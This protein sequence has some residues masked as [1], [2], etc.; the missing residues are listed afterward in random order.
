MCAAV[1]GSAGAPATSR[2]ARCE[3][4]G[5]ALA[6]AGRPPAHV[7]TATGGRGAKQAAKP[8]A[9]PAQGRGGAAAAP[10]RPRRR[11]RRGRHRGRAGTHARAPPGRAAAVAPGGA[12]PAAARRPARAQQR[13][14][15]AR[16]DGA[17]ASAQRAPL[18]A[19]AAGASP[20]ATRP[21][22]PSAREAAA[23]A[24][25]GARPDRSAAGAWRAVAGGASAR[26]R[27]AARAS[28]RVAAVEAVAADDHARRCAS[29]MRRS[30]RQERCSMYQR[31]SSMRSSHGSAARPLTCAQP[32]MPGL[33]RQAPALALGVAVDLDLDRRARADDRHLAAQHVDE[34]RQLVE[35]RAAQQAPDAR[36]PRVALVDGQAGAHVLGAG[37]HR[38]QLEEVER[39]AV[40]A[41]AALAVD[42][43]A[44]R[45]EP[46]R[47]DRQRAAAGDATS[48][49]VPGDDDVEARRAISA[50][51]PAAPSPPA[52][53]GAGSPTGRRRATPW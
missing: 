27:W 23:G 17:A 9:A 43:A 44:A 12:A 7:A 48:S 14:G 40:L 5:A 37:D 1:A 13:A 19:G 29:R 8:I 36:D 15:A 26:S 53:R 10:A 25:G 50:C 46:D 34:V 47:D 49:A 18:R 2:C 28:R 4:H 20:R 52:C 35:R 3:L 30:R 21:G 39:A 42:R 33:D 51:P 41:D 16:S 22:T 24:H 6:R 38:A 11:A 45:L 32:V 31:S